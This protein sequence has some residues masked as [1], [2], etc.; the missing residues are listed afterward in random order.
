MSNAMRMG[1]K[2]LASV[3]VGAL[4]ASLLVGL[5]A[6]SAQAA[7]QTGATLTKGGT[8]VVRADAAAGTT[9]AT[10]WASSAAQVA[11]T[12]VFSAFARNGVSLGTVPSGVT[13]TCSDGATAGTISGGTI[14]CSSQAV[15]AAA[16]AGTLNVARTLAPGAY[17]YTVTITSTDATVTTSKAETG[18]TFYVAAGPATTQSF[19]KASYSVIGTGTATAKLSLTDSNGNPTYLVSGESVQVQTGSSLIATNSPILIDASNYTQA[20]A[21][22]G[23]LSVTVTGVSAGDTT[24]TSARTSGLTGLA[25]ASSAVSVVSAPVAASSAT[26]TESQDRFV[27]TAATLTPG[28]A[29]STVYL[30]TAASTA[31][32][33]G[34]STAAGTTQ[35]TIAQNGSNPLPA[36]VTAGTSFVTNGSAVSGYATALTVTSTNPVAGTSYLVTVEAGN[37]DLVFT[38]VYQAPVIYKITAAPNPVATTLGGPVSVLATVTDQFAAPVNNAP[39]TFTVSGRNTRSGSGATNSAGEYA[40][41]YT[42]AGTAASVTSDTV[43]VNTPAIQATG[44]TAPTTQATSTVNYYS[45]IAVSAV[46]AAGSPGAGAGYTAYGQAVPSG[47]AEV[48]VQTDYT[49]TTAG[50]NPQIT[51]GQVELVFTVT[52]TAGAVSGIPVAVTGT[53]GTF[54]RAGGT[55]ALVPVSGALAKT[56]LNGFTTS[57]TYTVQANFT[58]TGTATVTATAGGKTATYAVTVKNAG[59]DAHTVTVTPATSSV[60]PASAALITAKVTDGF[61]NAVAGVDLTA[62]ATAPGVF[63]ALSSITAKTNAAGTLDLSL[64]SVGGAAGNSSVLVAGPGTG[65]LA[66]GASAN[67]AA[68]LAFGFADAKNSGTSTVTFTATPGEKSILIAGYRSGG[69]VVVEGEATG[70]ARGDTVNIRVKFYNANKKKYTSWRGAGSAVVKGSGAFVSSISTDKQVRIKVNGG[71]V[72]S[73]VVTVS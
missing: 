8:S 1:K 70:F 45:S 12:I 32:I 34:A 35:Y 61:G 71:G 69:S 54:F 46:T 63:G 65:Q 36:G 13:A 7:S 33:E 6:T 9:A 31:V 17:T 25:N 42:D 10:T 26:F 60:S 38:V 40:V 30:S 22:T 20:A 15:A 27:T 19:D 48:L 72:V 2:S 43:T 68:A 44:S 56:S 5:T 37:T 4:G 67:A 52:S 66:Y 16:V 29:T 23:S 24:L 59:T 41:T 14:T 49:A 51:K 47:T 55:D 50:Q 64:T 58:K 57:G 18:Q 62:S 11:G 28:A 21:T 73:N 53:P 3:A 39:V